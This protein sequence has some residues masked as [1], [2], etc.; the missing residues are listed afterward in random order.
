MERKLF[1]FY[2]NQ[3]KKWRH[4]SHFNLRICDSPPLQIHFRFEFRG[5]WTNSVGLKSR[6]I[7]VCSSSITL[8]VPWEETEIEIGHFLWLSAN[9][10]IFHHQ[11]S[12][13]SGYDT[14]FWIWRPGFNSRPGILMLFFILAFT[15]I[16]VFFNFLKHFSLN[17]KN[18]FI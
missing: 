5:T 16:D 8:F 3:N 15:L 12:W 7:T 2:K 14:Y 4:K 18:V 13:S 11:T 1:W 6:S 9:R 10:A 17:L